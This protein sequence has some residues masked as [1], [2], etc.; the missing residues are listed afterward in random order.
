MPRAL[1]E[2]LGN[3]RYISHLDLMR[4]FQ[5]AFKRAGL[6]LTHTQGFN[7]R[8]SV[9]IALPLSL[10]V[11]S[12]CELL[13]FDLEHPCSCDE[14][15]GRLNAALIDGVHIRGVYEQ[16]QKLKDLALLQ[17]R[18][19]LEYDRQ[20]PDAV[21]EQIQN[22]FFQPELIV[23]KKG[24]NGITQQ[25]IIPMIRRLSVKRLTGEELEISALHSCQNPSLNPMQLVA[26][27]TKY[28]P[29][30]A[31]DYVRCFREEIYDANETIFR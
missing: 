1:F 11:E 13:D 4:V 2:K 29:E 7:P 12:R 6:P 21:Y 8:P 15:C 9:S 16:G 10:G 30:L 3:A 19:V 28:L 26:A 22:L 24:K 27:V 14:I 5:R 25:D 31:P 17:S 18:L 23:E 20:I